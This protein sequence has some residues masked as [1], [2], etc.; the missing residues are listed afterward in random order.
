MGHWFGQ[1]P[2][3]GCLTRHCP[4]PDSLSAVFASPAYPALLWARSTVVYLPRAVPAYYLRYC[5]FSTLPR[6]CL[7]VPFFFLV[8]YQCI[9]VP[10]ILSVTYTRSSSSTRFGFAAFTSSPFSAEMIHKPKRTSCTCTYLCCT[11]HIPG[12]PGTNV[13]TRLMI[14]TDM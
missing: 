4:M 13:N 1:S 9:V 6:T 11:H 10:L 7:Y 5:H 3:K 12:I 8:V 2:F 14:P